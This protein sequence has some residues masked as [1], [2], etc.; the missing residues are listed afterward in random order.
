MELQIRDLDQ[1][2]VGNPAHDVIRLSLSLAMAARGADLPGVTTALMMEQVVVGYR[3]ALLGQERKT[4]A[5][6]VA[7]V[8]LVMR[9]ALNRKWRH[10]A[11]ERIEDV[12]PQIP[13][14]AKF[15]QLSKAEKD[16]IERL[17]APEDVR[18]LAT[19]LKER[20]NKSKVRVL[21]AAY[22]MKA[23]ALWVSCDSPFW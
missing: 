10:L 21:D 17:F 8:N 11:P 2:V 22:W 7:P 18:N 19:C 1:T 14:R 16:E 6:D 23:A 12:K 15:W 9:Q 13:L 5:Q 4:K 20:S 3:Q